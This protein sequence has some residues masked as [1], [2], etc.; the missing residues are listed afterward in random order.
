M[1]RITMMVAVALAVTGCRANDKQ[2]EPQPTS[3]P[4]AV[5]PKQGEDAH[6][7]EEDKPGEAHGTKQSSDANAKEEEHEGEE[8]HAHGADGDADGDEEVIK[9]A[10]EAVKAAQIT[11]VSAERRAFAGTFGAPARV[12][13]PQRGVAR[14][15]ARV[16]GL[17]EEVRV[18][19]GEH[20]KKGAVL[21]WIQSPELGQARAEFLS[22]ATKLRIAQQ[23]YGREN[24]LLKKGISSEREAREAESVLAVARADLHS[25]EA[26]LHTL[27]VT[28][29]ELSRYRAE[30]HPTARFAI[31]SPI[32]GTV[33][34]IAGT[35][36]QSLEG[37]APLFTIGDLSRLW[38]IADVYESQLSAIQTGKGAEVVVPA[39][40]G[41]TF[42]GTVEAIGDVVDEKTRTI[43]VRIVVPN[44]DRAL[45]PGMFGT[46]QI[47][48]ASARAANGT[49]AAA[50]VIVPRDAVQ[51]VGER[52]VVF[53]PAGENQ[54][55]PVEV[56]L[57]AESAGEIEIAAGIEPGTQV[58]TRGSFTLKSELSK[59][60]LS[61]GHAGH[62]H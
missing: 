46:V 50:G 33:V 20:V 44:A 59:E 4:G 40:P 1:K 45:K 61:G 42:R 60:S 10:P 15:G 36:G 3:K 12:T 53:V 37:T 5:A 22:A 13:F 19:L 23:N 2:P 62:G 34:E 47:A 27:G 16:P 48:V 32:D 24:E 8:G 57:G 25:A 58:V 28:D 52:T 6:D 49:D 38:V 43:A 17:L 31:R 35:M 56:K 7:H 11:L 14:V 9:L 39:A 21:G 41:R 18:E 51:K 55:R 26:K 54:F 30:D 29:E